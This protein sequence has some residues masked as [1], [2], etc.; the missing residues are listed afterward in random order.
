M[1]DASSRHALV[2]N[3]RERRSNG[4]PVLEELLGVPA[5]SRGVPTLLRLLDRHHE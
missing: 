4:T 1:L 5:T 3:H 2:L